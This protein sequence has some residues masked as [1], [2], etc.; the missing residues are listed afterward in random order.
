MLVKLDNGYNYYKKMKCQNTKLDPITVAHLTRP[1][2]LAILFLLSSAVLLCAGEF[3]AEAS[4]LKYPS[5]RLEVAEAFLDAPLRNTKD[6]LVQG[7]QVFEDALHRSGAVYR[8]FELEKVL[9]E[10]LPVDVLGDKAQGFR[11]RIYVLKDPTV[12]AMTTPTGS[13]YINSGLLAILGNTDQLRLV[14]GHEVHHILNQDIVH[15]YKKFKEEVGAIRLIQLLAAPVAA[16]AVGTSD[17]DTGRVI[18]NV[19]TA[20]NL[21]VSISYRLAFLG[22]GREAENQC[23]Q[24]ALR[25]FNKNH[26]DLESAKRVFQLFEDEHEKYGQG[27]RSHFFLDHETGKQRAERVE[28]FMK[29]VAYEGP[30]VAIDK[31]DPRY[32]ERTQVIRLENAKLNIKVK[33]PQHAIDDLE[34]LR[35]AFPQEARVLC[36]L[37]RAYTMISEDPKYLKQELSGDAWKKLKIKDEKIQKQAWADKAVEYFTQSIQMDVAYADPYKDLASLNEAQEKYIDAEKNLQKYLA[38][39]PQAKDVRYIKAKLEKIKDKIKSVQEE[40]LKSKG[41]KKKT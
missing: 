41:R 27:F 37:G 22:Y 39:S 21:T 3:S 29:E 2:F 12:N 10:I 18:A 17:A 7:A 33:R 23:D 15:Q 34:R 24:F 19:Y 25:I 35:K 40:E 1:A 20:A 26:Y 32:D 28:K 8:D 38:L 14:L 31:P 30:A 36:L 4:E 11:Y 5:I 6:E 13:I 16:V 9:Q